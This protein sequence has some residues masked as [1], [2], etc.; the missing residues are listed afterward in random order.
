MCPSYWLGHLLDI[1]PGQFLRD[2]P[3]VQHL[4]SPEFLILPILTCV[5]WNLRVV[6]ICISL[7]IKDFEHFFRCFSAIRYSSGENSLFS[8]EHHFLIVLY[9]FLVSTLLSSL[10]IFLYIYWI[11]VPYLIK[12]GKDPFPICWWPS[13]LIDCVFCL[14]EALQF[15]EVPFVNPRSYSTSH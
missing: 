10:Y 12:I 14:A 5:R 1:C 15:Y 8:S 11:L 6:L 3:V 9:N 4:L 2:P 7:M 13:C